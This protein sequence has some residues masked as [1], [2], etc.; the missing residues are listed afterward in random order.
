MKRYFFSLIGLLAI[1]TACQSN[2]TAQETTDSLAI[3]TNIVAS[4]QQSCY[5]YIKDRDTANIT[6]MSS[7]TIITGELNYQLF[8][9]DK[10][11][12]TFK[13]EMRGDTLFAD[14][15]FNAEGSQSVREVAF[16]KKGTQLLEAFG[17]VEDKNGKMIFKDKRK[18]T[19]GQSIVFN[20][21][22]CH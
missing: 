9:K 16:L 5:T 11:K 6:L 18:L 12:G 7:G 2:K 13:G 19:F 4:T 1:F 17:D 14:Y 3:D 20:Q 10:N 8:E 15:T 21:T 22:D